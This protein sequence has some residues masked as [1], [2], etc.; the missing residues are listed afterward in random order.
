MRHKKRLAVLDY[1][2]L[3]HAQLAAYLIQLGIRDYVRVPYSIEYTKQLLEEYP[4]YLA[5]REQKLR[6]LIEERTA[7]EEKAEKILAALKQMI[8]VR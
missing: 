7:D 8:G 4:R 3:S 1:P 2:D 6:Q 5:R